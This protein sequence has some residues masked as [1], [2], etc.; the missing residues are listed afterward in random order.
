MTYGRS[1][2]V[3]LGPLIIGVT[4][5]I[6]FGVFGL[7]FVRAGNAAIQDL[8]RANNQATLSV[9]A[10]LMSEPL[11][12]ADVETLQRILE[13]FRGETNIAHAEV[14]DPNG[15][16]LAQITEEWTPEEA[17]ALDLATQAL[18]QG[19]VVHREIEGH[20]VSCSPIAAGTEQIGTLTIVFDQA[21]VQALAQQ[22]KNTLHPTILGISTAIIILV[23]V[24]ARVFT[25]PIHALA[26]AANEIGRGNLNV[27]IPARGTE[28]IAALGTALD[29]MRTDLQRLY[30]GME[31]QMTSLERRA[32]YLEATAEVAREATST[33]DPQELLSRVATLISERFNFYHTGI[34]LVDSSGEWAVLQAASGAGARRMLARQ[35]RLK[36][37][38]EGIVGY[39]TGRGEH[40]IA[41]DAGPDAVF[42][43]NPDLPN[44]RSEIA[45]PLRARGEIIGALDVQSTEPAAFSDEDVA[46]LQTLADQIAMAISNAQLF[47]QV[48]ESLEATRRAYGEL[49]RQAWAEM[50]RT[51]PKTG[52]YCDDSGTIPIT[53]LSDVHGDG[54]LPAISIPVKVR[55]QVIGTIRTRKPGEAG[56]WTPQEIALLETLTERLAEALESA[57]L[58]ED[59]QSRA[60]RERL[61]G[62]ITARM[63]QT[64]DLE[65]VLETAVQDIRQALNLPEVTVRL[66]TQPRSE[67]DGNGGSESQGGVT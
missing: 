3:T 5:L 25:A 26:A 2:L 12:D 49:S 7:V 27:P 55:G 29:N 19:G 23:A 48:Q 52:Y 36:V 47:R 60:W 45:L 54:E 40:R 38:Q 31:Q 32:N 18:A 37:G 10:R 62:E 44:T 46:V 15:Q 30:R 50:V 51:R 17:V 14:R 33:L 43:D 56:E 35:H 67:T 28:E 59:A 13:G 1:K 24:F 53:K 57:R 8:V 42:F 64:L 16:I 61:V 66:T 22:I 9:S 63:R 20:L 4:V 6:A 41:L 58:Y 21:A 11:S 65:T 39:V 34:F